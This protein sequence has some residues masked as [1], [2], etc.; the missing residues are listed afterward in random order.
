MASPDRQTPPDIIEA[1]GEEP[2]GFDFFRAV[3]ILE[4]QFSD[5]PRVGESLSPRQDALRF[6]QNPSLAFAAS[7]LEGFTPGANGRPASLQVN[8]AGLFGPNGPLPLHVTEHARDRLRN[9]NDPSMV[10]FLNVFHHRFLSLFYRAWAVN[11][12]TADFDRPEDSRYASYIGALFGIGMESL[13][14][15]DAVS[16]WAK[17]YFAGR[18]VCQTRN[19]EGLE[20]IIQD[21]F[22]MPTEIEPFCGH[23]MTLPPSSVCQL[24]ASPETGSLGVTTIL[25]SR[26]WECQLKFRI[27]LGPVG[28]AEFSRLL[29]TAESFKQLKTWVLT[30]VNHELFWDAQVILK[31][32]EVPETRLGQAGQLG[33]TCWIRSQPFDHDADDLIL[34]GSS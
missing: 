30:Y 2:H 23:W 20:A 7:T 17:L 3:R 19:A 5:W 11:Q 27:R 33:W 29:P 26:F 1:L 16:D 4:A 18:L 8:F 32:E 14:N 22:G 24:G 9:G 13:R 31:K 6:Q 25:G 34:D 10:A 12:K 15:R 21:Y 28:L